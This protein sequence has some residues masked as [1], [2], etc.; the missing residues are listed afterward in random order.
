[1][2]YLRLANLNSLGP[3]TA[4]GHTSTIMAVENAVNYSL[5]VIKP[6]LDGEASAVEA[7]REAEVHYSNQMQRDL[8]NTVW[9]SGC[10]SWYV[11]E[12]GQE[13]KQWNAM[14]YPYSQSYYWYRCL[15][16]VWS[17]WNLIVS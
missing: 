17:D 1:M 14:T 9:A 16:P 5:R 11:K 6:V 2:E 10:H 13:G 8:K 12:D 15:L 4:T 7:R 3:N